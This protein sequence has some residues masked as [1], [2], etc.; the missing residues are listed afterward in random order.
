MRK[1]GLPFITLGVAL[2]AIGLTTNR[3]FMFAGLAFIFVA[4]GLMLRGG[5]R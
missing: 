5:R 2:I 1:A 4:L 3:T